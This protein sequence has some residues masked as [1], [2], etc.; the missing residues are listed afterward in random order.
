MGT[1]LLLQVRRAGQRRPR[2]GHARTMRTEG[3]GVLGDRR[4]STTRRSRRGGGRWR[5]GSCRGSLRPSCR[6]SCRTSIRTR[7]D[8]IRRSCSSTP[9]GRSRLPRRRRRALTDAVSSGKV[10]FVGIHS[11]TDTLYQ[12]PAYGEMIG[13]YFD[14]HPWTADTTV[15][16]RK[17]E[18]NA[19]T[20]PFPQQFQLTE[21]IYQMKEYDRSKC[22]VCM[23]LD[24]TKTDMTRQGIKRTDGDF[25][26]SWVKT[27]GKGAR[28]LHVHGAQRRDVRA[29]GLPEARAGGAE[30]GD[31]GF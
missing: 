25:P 28:V 29:R 31:G 22:D 21:E 1:T 15:T 7:S 18:E 6:T 30:V 12:W 9:P 16:I 14:G 4:G 19:V 17:E 8:S 23:S 26:V 5:W 11:A 3:A 24:T 10:G 20:K 2:A 27:Y 13:G